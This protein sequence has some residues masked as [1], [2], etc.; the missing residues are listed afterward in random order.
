LPQDVPTPNVP[1]EADQ[2]RFH[3]DLTS[4]IGPIAPDQTLGI[5]FSGGP[6]SLA[7]LLL[8]HASFPG[9]TKAA[10]VDHG[11]RAES[12]DEARHCAT[13]CVG[14]GIPHTM[15]APATPITGSLQAAARTARYQL[16]SEWA[17]ANAISHI[18][19]GHH[20][21]D[22]AETL[23]M[24]LNR[25]SGLAGLAGIRATNGRIVR[26]VLGWRR[27]ELAGLA[28]LS[29]LSAI[30]DPSNQNDRFDRARI[31]KAMAGA[32]W[33]DTIAMAKSAAALADSEEALVWMTQ[34]LSETRLTV[35]TDRCALSEPQT[36]P[37]EI[38]RR[39]VLAALKALDPAI[40]PSGPELMRFI[41]SLQAGSKASIGSLVGES[42]KN[43]WFFTKAPPRSP[44]GP[45]HSP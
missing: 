44:R 42:R 16:L 9:Q 2:D 33:L 13:I 21:D 35:S 5:A 30:A 1:P 7:L 38:G 11:L 6:D 12:A 43:Q 28:K 39:L 3:A 4:L 31:R 19:T 29:G 20:A 14:L 8:C 34:S 23:F 25:G 40:A 32:D 27:D 36:L 22:Q 15:L 45:V 26:P 41:A 18:L 17:D 24:R 37:K 10:T